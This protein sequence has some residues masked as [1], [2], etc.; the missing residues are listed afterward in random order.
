MGTLTDTEKVDVRR[1]CGYGEFGALAGQGFAYRF[2]QHYGNLEYRLQNSLPEEETVI[3]QYLTDLHTLEAAVPA[4]ST[5]LDTAQAAVWQHNKHEVRDRMRLFNTWRR[6]LC[7]FLG[8][9]PGPH[10]GKG[11]IE[12]VV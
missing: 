11:G 2:F 12:I 10:L 3:R 6:Q 7:G 5:N 4:S 8:V 9:A 1:Y